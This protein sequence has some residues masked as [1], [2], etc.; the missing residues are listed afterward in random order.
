MVCFNFGYAPQNPEN[1]SA[2][3]G[4]TDF[5]SVR[6]DIVQ[7]ASADNSPQR[8]HTETLKAKYI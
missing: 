4:I 8:E 5:N 2:A 7:T 3:L 1:A 6:K